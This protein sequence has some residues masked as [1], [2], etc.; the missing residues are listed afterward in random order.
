MDPT[1]PSFATTVSSTP[2]RCEDHLAYPMAN[3]A[4]VN[5]GFI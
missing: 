4:T 5:H 1:T 3:L 2:N